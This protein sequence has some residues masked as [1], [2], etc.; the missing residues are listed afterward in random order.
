MVQADLFDSAPAESPA[1]ELARLRK[2][3]ARLRDGLVLTREHAESIAT[4]TGAQLGMSG[5]RVALKPGCRLSVVTDGQAS[6]LDIVR[7]MIDACGG[8][9]V[10]LLLSTWTAGVR[11]V[12]G[13][14]LLAERGP[15]ADL[16]MIVDTSFARKRKQSSDEDL[17]SQIE[18]I[19]HVFGEDAVRVTATH[20]KVYVVEGNGLVFAA[21]GSLNLN[22]NPRLENLDICEGDEAAWWRDALWA[23]SEALP[24]TLE[25]GEWSPDRALSAVAAMKPAPPAEGF[26]AAVLARMAQLREDARAAGQ[27]V[28]KESLIPGLAGACKMNIAN[29][30]AALAQ[31]ASD[32]LRRKIAN[33]LQMRI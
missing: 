31:G 18:T 22:R 11:D 28:P 16:R 27:P 24:T 4:Q 13:L 19:R 17:M 6:A 25:R 10:R 15:V 29:L 30:R 12:D 26:K 14:R 8:S 9:G 2:E 21:R 20:A 33:V 5:L 1:S 3:N 32:D 7:A 23:M